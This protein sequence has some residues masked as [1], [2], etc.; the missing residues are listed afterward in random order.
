MNLGADRMRNHQPRRMP[1]TNLL[2]AAL[3]MACV[4]FAQA[5]DGAA[6]Q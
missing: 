2:A 3:L 1:P 4:P 6:A 5:A